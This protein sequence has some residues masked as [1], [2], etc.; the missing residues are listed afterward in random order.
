MVCLLSVLLCAAAAVWAAGAQGEGGAAAPEA[1]TNPLLPTDWSLQI[2]TVLT[3][4]AV[5][6][7]LSKFAYKPLRRVLAQ[8]EAAIRDSLAQAEKARD[9]A[10]ELQARNAEQLADARRKAREMIE[11]G[12]AFSLRIRREAEAEAKRRAAELIEEARKEVDEE[13]RRTI[14]DLRGSVGNIAVR[15]ARQIIGENLDER[16]HEALVDEFVERLK[17]S[18]GKGPGTS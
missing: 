14:D 1:E 16:R 3:F 6:L 8:R 12:Q 7:V 17:R 9:D 4:V 10:R 18:Y 15:I 11:E 13:L 2:W 5:M